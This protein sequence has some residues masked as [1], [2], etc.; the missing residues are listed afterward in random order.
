VIPKVKREI[1]VGATEAGNEVVF[2]RVDG[3]FSGIAVMHMGQD[4]LE[5][6]ILH[7][8]KSLRAW[9]ASLSNC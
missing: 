5:I 4:Q 6:H 7:H 8:Q 2:E 1:F 9:E 3:T